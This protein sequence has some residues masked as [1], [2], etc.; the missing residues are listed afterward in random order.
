MKQISAYA[1]RLFLISI[2]LS[3]FALTSFAQ[4]GRSWMNG[5]IFADSDTNGLSGANVELTGDQSNARL[6]SV[7][8]STRAENDGKYSLKD[9][10]YGAYTFRVS[11]DGYEPYEIKLYV[12]SDMLTQI[13][14]RL[15]RKE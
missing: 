9:I 2:V 12:G 1:W 11:A 8:L 3:G 5:F 4:S 14:V 10:P 13:H 15:R 7:H 6:K